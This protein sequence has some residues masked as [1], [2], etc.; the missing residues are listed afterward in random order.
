MKQSIIIPFH[1]NK[2][3]L[4]YCLKTLVKTLPS[5]I[6]IVIVGNN[7]NHEEIDFE[8]PNRYKY[9]KI[10]K[11]I[12]YPNAVNYGVKH[13]TGEIITICDPDVFFW[14]DWYEPMIQCLTQKDNVGAVS[15]KLIN[16][17]NNRILD[18]GMYYTKYNA[19]H[20]TMGLKYDHPLASFDRKVQTACSAV[21]MTTRDAFTKVNGMDSELPYSYTEC[22]YC[23]KLK[24]IGLD[25]WV[26][27]DSKAYHKGSTDPNNSKNYA[28]SYYNQDSKAMFAY[29][30]YG[31]INYNVNEWFEYTCTYAKKHISNLQ[32]KYLLLDFS[33][34]YDRENFYYMIQKFLNIEFLDCHNPIVKSRNIRS[35]PLYNYISFKYIDYASPILYFVDIFTCLFDNELWFKMRD[36]SKDLV[37]DRHGNVFPLIDIANHNC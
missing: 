16:P 27:A 13:S 21:M 33:T 11:N 29:K 23:L 37:I 7:A 4:F 35:L 18:F 19:I 26:V 32:S 20:S 25:T 6:E 2:D 22:D 28:F 31:R 5:D 8:L 1:K 30:N 14:E 12:Q 24:S 34:I 17:L 10:Y 36:I 15:L 3:M 9:Y